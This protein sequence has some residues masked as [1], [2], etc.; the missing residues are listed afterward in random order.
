MTQLLLPIELLTKLLELPDSWVI[1]DGKS[2]NNEVWISLKPKET[3]LSD[4]LKTE[5]L[6]HLETFGNRTY[7]KLY[8]SNEEDL[9]KLPLYTKIGFCKPFIM[10]VRKW[11]GTATDASICNLYGLTKKELNKIK[12]ECNPRLLA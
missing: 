7:I 2:E 8:F 10:D 3:P 5:I 12:E 4:D 9:N 6:R 11:F 1:F